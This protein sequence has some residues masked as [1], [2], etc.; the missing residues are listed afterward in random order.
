MITRNTSR[1]SSTGTRSGWQVTAADWRGQAG[2]GRLGADDVTGHIDDFAHVDRRSRRVL[3]A[4]GRASAPGPHVLAGHSMGGHLALRAVA[5][6][7]VAPD[8][9]VLV[10]PMLGLRRAAAAGAACTRSPRA[11]AALG[12]PRRPAWKWSEKP[13]EVPAPRSTC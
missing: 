5:E 4:N 8:A 3:G 12:D 2:S 10:A 7:R 11:M 9:L 6:G 1:R 13:G